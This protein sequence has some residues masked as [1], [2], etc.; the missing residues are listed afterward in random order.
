MRVEK[1]KQ[2]EGFTIVELLIVIIV[3]GI[4]AALV[5][6]SFG[7]IRERAITASLQSDL[8]NGVKQLKAYRVTNGK[9]PEVIDDCPTPASGK[10]CLKAS[11]GN[12]LSYSYDN[13]TSPKTFTLTATNGDI[14]YDATESHGPAS[15]E[16]V[17]DLI[18]ENTS[19]GRSGTIQTWTVPKT[20]TY[21][22]EAWGAQGGSSSTYAGGKG[23]RMRGEF[24]LNSGDVVKI[25]VGQK[26][27]SAASTSYSG[28]GG[29]GT[30]VWINGATTPLLVAG[31]GGGAGYNS[32]ASTVHAVVGTSSPS[33][34]SGCGGSSG[35][36]GGNAGAEGAGGAGWSGNGSDYS[37]TAYGGASPANGGVGGSGYSSTGGDGGFG[38]GGGSHHGGG[39]G[40]GYSGGGCGSHQYSGG[41]AGSYNAGANPSNTA[42]VRTGHGLVTIKN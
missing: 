27:N 5:L 20:D 39:G 17:V 30:Y 35:G 14:A 6:V 12:S 33:V 36:S 34:S 24:N 11:S 8:H 40:G 13:S 22:I 29:G 28:G 16:I 2:Q 23:A 32:P 18:F 15:A 26:G 21:T 7:G 10:M 31:G 41:G 19:T 42:A 1:R 3:I 37:T 9:Y 38:G 25:I 4:L